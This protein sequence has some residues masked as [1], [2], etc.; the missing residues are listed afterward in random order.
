MAKLLFKVP[1]FFQS[2]MRISKMFL[3]VF[4]ASEE[5]CNYTIFILI[6]DYPC[7]AKR[8]FVLISDSLI[9]RLTWSVLCIN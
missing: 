8:A 4:T 3:I 5:K 1:V 9:I 6:E 2:P 7:R